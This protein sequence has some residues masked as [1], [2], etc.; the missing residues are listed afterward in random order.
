M[1]ERHRAYLE[2]TVGLGLTLMLGV[3]LSLT[4]GWA[5][6]EHLEVSYLYEAVK[7]SSFWGVAASLQSAEQMHQPLFPWV[8]R[9]WCALGGTDE[10]WIR[11]P[12]IAFASLTVFVA[13]R[14]ARRHAGPLA[15]LGAALLVA[16]SPLVVWYGKDCSPYA[17]LALLG[18]LA[19]WSASDL[20]ERPSRG[21]A[22]RT[23]VILALAFYTHFFGAW[24][25]L[26]VG[27]W[28]LVAP[29]SAF[30]PTIWVTATTALL[31]LPALG[32]LVEKLF[33]SVHGLGE[34]QPVMR[35][36]HTLGEAIP[37]ALRVLFGGEHWLFVVGLAL[38]ALGAWRSDGALR[39][40]AW[41]AGA[42]ALLAELH[43]TWQIA[44]SK[45]IV[46]VDIRHY[47]FLVPL[48]ALLIAKAGRWAIPLAVAVQLTTSAPMLSGTLDKPDARAAVS[49]VKRHA[50]TPADAV[51][52]LPAPW[53]SGIVEY[54][55]L[56]VCPELV[57]GRSFD[58]WWTPATCAL[59]EA[60]L[61]GA[62]FG[63]PFGTERVWK[64]HRHR[65][66]KRLWLIDL[67]DHRFGLPVAPSS[68]QE[69]FACWPGLGEVQI[70]G[71]HFGPWA[72]VRVY[73]LEKLDRL[74]A[75]PAPLERPVESVRAGDVWPIKCP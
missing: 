23:G 7:P 31:C 33:T 59:S 28:L 5:S 29:A 52:F 39:K 68:P 50:V 26:I 57:H 36:S 10:L 72:T 45:G 43:V 37:E 42:L 19:F 4:A 20:L 18:A 8:L 15:A 66:L 67:R 61:P 48:V 58:G 35:Y 55:L 25:A 38:T 56:G 51:S 46:Y 74:G 73:D 3:G 27:A 53:Y 2:W 16:T 60:A 44:R 6:I 24:L 70:A 12:S 41:V 21:R 65:E 54:Y 47:V 13:W 69:D 63:F 75:P 40:L 14:F 32:L 64:A 30:R 11:L 49:W 17:L 62:V 71:R 1:T 34:D 9:L 22:I